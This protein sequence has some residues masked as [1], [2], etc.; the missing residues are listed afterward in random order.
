MR[1]PYTE[2]SLGREIIRVFC[3]DAP[4]DEF[5]WHRDKHDRYITVA[6]SRGWFLQL[7]NELP[8][9]LIEG[10]SYFVRKNEWHRILK[11]AGDLKIKI[12]EF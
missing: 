9:E 5:V 7:E 3:S 2:Q 11:G 12:R 4:V 1:R 8:T 10:V 6:E